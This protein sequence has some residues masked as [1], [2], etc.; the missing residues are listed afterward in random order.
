MKFNTHTG[1]KLFLQSVYIA[2]LILSILF[3]QACDETNPSSPEEEPDEYMVTAS[4]QHFLRDGPSYNWNQATDANG[5]YY[6]AYT[7]TGT[8]YNAVAWS[9]P[10]STPGHYEVQV[11]IPQL[12]NLVGSVTYLIVA[13]GNQRSVNVNQSASAGS[14]VVLGTFYF[15]A[16]GSEYIELDNTSTRTGE[17]IAFDAMRWTAI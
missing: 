2:S 11:Y 8:P 1:N 13:D 6:W 15:S 17:R 4:S 5:L 7:A 14:W 12:N 9:V 16:D 10:F 3:L